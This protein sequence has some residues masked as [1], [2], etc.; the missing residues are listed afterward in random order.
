MM[1]LVI[2]NDDYQYI[3]SRYFRLGF[4]ERDFRKFSMLTYGITPPPGSL[5]LKPI[6]TV[7]EALEAALKLI[8]KIEEKYRDRYVS[9]VKGRYWYEVYK[10]NGTW[11]S[12]YLGQQLPAAYRDY[13]KHT[14]L[15]DTKQKLIKIISEIRDHTARKLA[16][17]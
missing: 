14:V 10:S 8:A 6:R 17:T 13:V 5:H 1:F 4:L 16:S 3:F 15:Q 7:P 9:L 2:V 11:H 12:R